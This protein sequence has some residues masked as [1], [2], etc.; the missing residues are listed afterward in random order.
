MA[1]SVWLATWARLSPV[2]MASALSFSHRTLVMRIMLRRISTVNR[3]SGALSRICSC[4]A[5]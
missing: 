2:T 5:V 4:A 1:F 3:S